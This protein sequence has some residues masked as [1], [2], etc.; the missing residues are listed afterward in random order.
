M[1]IKTK[2][3]VKSIPNRDYDWEAWDGDNEEAS[4]VGYGASEQEAISDLKQ[5]LGLE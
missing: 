2:Y 3:N 4:P 1:N 5:L